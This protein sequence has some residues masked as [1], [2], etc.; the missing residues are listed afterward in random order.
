VAIGRNADPNRPCLVVHDERPRLQSTDPSVCR[1]VANPRLD[2]W[3]RSCHVDDGADDCRTGDTGEVTN[4]PSWRRFDET[5]TAPSLQAAQEST[6]DASATQS[7]EE[8]RR[9]CVRTPE[10][11]TERVPMGT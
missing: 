8:S 7:R 6:A 2:G 4:R 1:A 9:L 3:A 11:R 10:T 5:T